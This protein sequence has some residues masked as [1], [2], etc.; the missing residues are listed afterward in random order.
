[1]KQFL[2][3]KCKMVLDKK[4]H[5]KLEQTSPWIDVPNK[6]FHL[7]EDCYFDFIDFLD[8]KWVSTVKEDTPDDTDD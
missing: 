7:C 6:K 3:D 5:F 2:C 4:L 1:M 8:G